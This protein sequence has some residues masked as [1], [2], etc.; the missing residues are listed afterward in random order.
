MLMKPKKEIEKLTKSI[1]AENERL[2]QVV[3]AQKR[4][5]SLLESKWAMPKEKNISITRLL[6]NN[7]S[8]N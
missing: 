6:A 4:Y 2:R 5:I 8:K 7:Y 1:S 3:E